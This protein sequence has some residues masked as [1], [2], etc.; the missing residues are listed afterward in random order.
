MVSGQWTYEEET[1]HSPLTSDASA[2]WDGDSLPDDLFGEVQFTTMPAALP[3][4]LGSFPF[5]RAEE[6]FL[7]AILPIYEESSPVGMDV[8]LGQRDAG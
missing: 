8:F 7:E 2:F 3:K 6:R 1:G 4:R 5:W